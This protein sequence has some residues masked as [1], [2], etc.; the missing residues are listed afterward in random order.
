[1]RYTGKPVTVQNGLHVTDKGIRIDFTGPLDTSAASDPANYSVVQYNYKWTSNYG[2]DKY[3]VSSP[4]QKGVDTLEV[5]SATVAPDKKSVLLAIDGLQPVMQMEIK[6][7]IKSADGAAI[8]DKVGLTINVV[9]PAD[10][11][12]VTYVS[13]K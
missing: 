1:V 9:A 3:K 6:M 13:G 12:G 4:D 7:N 5:K 11:P 2:S 10:K 8:P